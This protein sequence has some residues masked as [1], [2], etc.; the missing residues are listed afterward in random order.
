MTGVLYVG[1]F[2]INQIRP[3]TSAASCGV[4]KPRP[5]GRKITGN[6]VP[7]IGLR[8]IGS[9][10]FLGPQSSQSFTQEFL[11]ILFTL[12]ASHPFS[13]NLFQSLS[14]SSIVKKNVG[15]ARP[16]CSSCAECQRQESFPACS[17]LLHLATARHSPSRLHQGK[18][19][20]RVS[21]FSTGH[22]WIVAFGAHWAS[23]RCCLQKFRPSETSGHRWHRQIMANTC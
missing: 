8:L 20:S 23:C 4:T 1:S 17:C 3:A 9:T 14:I 5:K 18:W 7:C 16:S 13:F 12:F 11:F 22:M 6:A 19:T 21:T 10:E 15:Q 2:N